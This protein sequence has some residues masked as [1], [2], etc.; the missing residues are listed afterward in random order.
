MLPAVRDTVMVNELLHSLYMC[1]ASHV[2]MDC[3]VMHL[4]SLS[5][6]LAF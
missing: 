4:M 5:C 3:N 6:K 1:P 2:N